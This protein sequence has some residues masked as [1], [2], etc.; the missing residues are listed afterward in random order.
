M[1]VLMMEIRIMWMRMNQRL[2]PMPMA[3]WFAR[4]VRR[5]VGVLMM[6]VVIMEVFVFHRV[7]PMHVFMTFSQM[8]PNTD[9]H[10]CSGDPQ[11]G[12]QLI[13]KKENGDHCACKWSS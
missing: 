12:S 4:R 9:R 3:V 6:L 5:A 7:V 8:Q 1:P 13:A 11:C 10:Q 2:V